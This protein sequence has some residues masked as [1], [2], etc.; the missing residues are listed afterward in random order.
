MCCDYLFFIFMKH[1]WC[2]L[3]LF[4]INETV[5]NYLNYVNMHYKY[6]THYLLRMLSFLLVQII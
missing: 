3:Y 2:I 1:V 4:C 5:F 6:T